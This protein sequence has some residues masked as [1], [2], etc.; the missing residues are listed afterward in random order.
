MRVAQEKERDKQG[1]ERQRQK[2]I[3][4]E[5]GRE[6]ILIEPFKTVLRKKRLTDNRDRDIEREREREREREYILT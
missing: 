2:D 1:K 6:R 3:K 4:N 5:R